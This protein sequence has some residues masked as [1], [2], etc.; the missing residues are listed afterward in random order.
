M[1]PPEDEAAPSGQAPPRP[2]TLVPL[3]D[4]E[5]WQL[6]GS[7]GVGR[8]VLV[9]GQRAEILPVNYVVASGSIVF[10][11]GA[12]GVLG[13]GAVWGRDVAFEVDSIDPTTAR[14]W[15]VVVH[16]ELREAHTDEEQ[17]LGAAARPWVAGS[18]PIVAVV[19]AGSISGR[20]ITG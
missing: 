12:S 16:G 19:R 7:G 10:R 20:R 5:C 1:Q 4:D 11:T 2:G 14:G 8:A 13:R 15:S 9:D 18:R 17:A 3:S 6:L